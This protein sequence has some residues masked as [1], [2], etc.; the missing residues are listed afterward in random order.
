MRRRELR[1]LSLPRE[2]HFSWST[3]PGLAWEAELIGHKKCYSLFLYIYTAE[4]SD[5]TLSFDAGYCGYMCSR[6]V[7]QTIFS[8]QGRDSSDIQDSR[9]VFAKKSRF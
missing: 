2:A 5:I 7:G 8:K 3:S 6:E 1:G 9:L 4:N